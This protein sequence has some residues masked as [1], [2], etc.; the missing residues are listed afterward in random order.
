MSYQ[1]HVD[2]IETDLMMD[3]I[4]SVKSHNKVYFESKARELLE[5]RKDD[6]LSLATAKLLVQSLNLK[7]ENFI[8]SPM[9]F[10]NDQKKYCK[11]RDEQEDK[12]DNY[13]GYENK[14]N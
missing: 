4:N 1:K 12:L 10:D 8:N 6:N 14:E 9:S 7:M 2:E 11:I 3:K 5:R 13:C